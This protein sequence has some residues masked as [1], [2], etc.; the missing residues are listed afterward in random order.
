[1][2]R[3]SILELIAQATADFP[4]NVSGLISPADLRTWAIDFLEAISPAYGVLQRT[5]PNTQNI[6]TTDALVVCNAAQDS[7]PAQTTTAVPASTIARAERGMSQ[8]NI[9]LDVECATNREVT[10]TLYKDG[11]PTS[12]RVTTSGRGTGSPV[13]VG[14]IALDY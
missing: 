5:S 3:K 2:A 7:N 4:N 13:G 9:N 8:I 14:M 1:M 6:G 11:A 10:L 12:W